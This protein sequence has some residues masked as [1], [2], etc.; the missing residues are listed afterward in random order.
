M[1]QEDLRISESLQW[2]PKWH[3]DPV[4][5]WFVERLDRAVLK[6][7]AIIHLEL[8]REMLDLQSQS[9]QRTLDVISKARK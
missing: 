1:A 3:W 2:N 7:I 6:Q 9:V 5:W 8:Q 4:P